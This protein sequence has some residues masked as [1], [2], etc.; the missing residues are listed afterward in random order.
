MVTD[1]GEVKKLSLRNCM[2]D[3]SGSKL[4]KGIG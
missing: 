4:Q 1:F 2:C 3:I